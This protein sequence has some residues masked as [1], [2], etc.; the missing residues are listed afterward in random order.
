MIF[1]RVSGLM[2]ISGNQNETRKLFFWFWPTIDVKYTDDLVFWT[3]GER[4][5]KYFPKC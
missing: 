1:V 3:N 5:I 4:E 2:P